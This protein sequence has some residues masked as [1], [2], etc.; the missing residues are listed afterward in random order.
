MLMKSSHPSSIIILLYIINKGVK[1][2]KKSLSLLI[3][4]ALVLCCIVPV[5]AEAEP[6]VGI[7]KDFSDK[8]ITIAADGKNLTCSIDSGTKILLSD[9]PSTLSEA[10]YKGVSVK[11]KISDGKATELN[12]A[13]IGDQHQ[14][15]MNMAIIYPREMVTDTN[16]DLY[17]SP[18][19]SKA[20]KT[21]TGEENDTQFSLRDL[22]TADLGSVDLV[23]DSLKVVLNGREIK[24]LYDEKEEFDKSAD[25][26]EL[27]ISFDTE[28]ENEVL[29]NFEKEISDKNSLTP[30][31]IA[32]ILK[33]SYRKKMYKLSVTE[34]YTMGVDENVHVELNGKE[35]SLP[36]AINR[37]NYAYYVLNP[38]GRIIYIN[39]FYQDL[40]CTITG[41][42]SD[43]ITISVDSPDITP[44]TDTLSLS[45]AVS[46]NGGSLAV[47]DLKVND[48]VKLTV[49]PYDG[50][51]VTNIVK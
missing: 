36:K 35:I 27:K 40:A 43:S 23:K 17:Y 31:E 38:Q 6:A 46:I 3:V 32:Q 20:S 16:T 25:N 28:N 42:K 7:V 4:M 19:T 37:S 21:E 10:A 50:Y 26:D 48:A 47:T 29:L 1:Q 33:I 41:I 24:V 12:F 2:L 49:D 18:A 22:K 15:Y 5:S 45:P 9:L 8:S 44:F 14:G 30:E 51:R 39:S 34:L 13:E 11:F